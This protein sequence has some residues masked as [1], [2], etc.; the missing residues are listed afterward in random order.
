MGRSL[1]RTLKSQVAP[2]VMT[3]ERIAKGSVSPGVLQQP[4]MPVNFGPIL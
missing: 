3:R 4:E 1:H 2:I